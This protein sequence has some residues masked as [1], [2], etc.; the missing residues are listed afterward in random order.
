MIKDHVENVMKK[1]LLRFAD[2]EDAKANDI[3]FYI[4]TKSNDLKPL[5]FYSAKGVIALENGEIKEL[6]FTRDFLGKKID[7]LG[8]SFLADNFL[9][10]YFAKISEEHNKD[11]KSMYVMITSADSECENLIIA[12]YHEQEELKQIKL[13]EIFLE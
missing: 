5:Y 3:S 13:D 4:H 7:L 6:R 9:T 8:I 10:K 12:I 2:K 1:A 11:P